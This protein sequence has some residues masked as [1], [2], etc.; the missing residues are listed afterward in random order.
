MKKLFTLL[1]IVSS[2][3]AS[4]Q[5]TWPKAYNSAKYLQFQ[6]DK[7]GEILGQFSHDNFASSFNHVGVPTTPTVPVYNESCAKYTNNGVATW[8]FNENYGFSTIIPFDNGKFFLGSFTSRILDPNGAP[9][10]VTFPTS[11]YTYHE[12]FSDQLLQFNGT[13]LNAIDINTGSVVNTSSIAALNTFIISSTY[14]KGSNL[15]LIGRY[16]STT[17]YANNVI[18]K[19][20]SAMTIAD[21]KTTSLDIRK[22]AITNPGTIYLCLNTEIGTFNWITAAYTLT[23]LTG[24]S[25]LLKYDATNTR[26]VY[27][28]AGTSTVKFIYDSGALTSYPISATGS[29]PTFGIEVD[30]YNNE[31]LINGSNSGP[32]GGTYNGSS[33]P[34]LATSSYANVVLHKIS[35]QRLRASFVVRN[36]NVCP[37]TPIRYYSNGTTGNPTNYSWSFPG[38]SPSTSTLSSPM[39]TYCNPGLYNASLTVSNCTSTH[40][41]NYTNFISV[42]YSNCSEPGCVSTVA[43][44]FGG[45]NSENAL[46]VRTDASGNIYTTGQFTGTVDFDPGAGV[47][48]LTSIASGYDMYITKFDAYGNFIWVK[49]LATQAGSASSANKADGLVIDNQGNLYVS[50]AYYQTVDFDP[51]AGVNT[52]TTGIYAEK[53]VLKLNT[54][55]EFVWVRKHG[56]SS[57]GTTASIAIDNANNIYIAGPLPNAT[58]TIGTFTITSAGNWDGYIARMDVLGNFVWAKRIGSSGV[59]YITDVKTNSAGSVVVGGLFSNTVDFDPNAG[60]ANL[61]SAGTYDAF[62]LTLDASGNYVW[63]KRTGSTGDD[64]ARELVINS[65]DDIILM[66]DYAGV[67]DFD[68]NAGVQNLTSAGGKDVY[69]QRL[70]SAGNYAWAGSMGSGTD[71]YG[72]AMSIDAA[73]NVYVSGDYSSGT[74]DV[75]PTAG[76]FNLGGTNGSYITK[77]N[78]SNAFVWGKKIDNAYITVMWNNPNNDLVVAGGFTGTT[79][80]DINAGVL[81]LSSNGSADA[82]VAK[83]CASSILRVATTEEVEGAI[84]TSTEALTS[85]VLIYPNP[86]LGQVFVSV[87][88]EWNTGKVTVYNSV[89]QIVLTGEVDSEHKTEFSLESLKDGLYFINVSNGE[90]SVTEKLIKNTNK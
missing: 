70:T 86:S 29:T 50:G 45:T 64:A 4:A 35:M 13:T 9:T 67:V 12:G 10:G 87:P 34:F 46:A 80:F 56:I 90:N 11:G 19:L 5:C 57:A 52:L 73:N 2:L 40:T 74:L 30:Y 59:D 88:A 27:F 79:D 1:F 47:S 55:G 68:P 82:F 16:F 8:M 41:A 48:T 61:T 76:V 44:S 37:G 33:F 21:V 65:A 17:N 84:A 51:G 89:G 3:I 28:N 69:V 53:F 77:I 15:Y 78:S 14:V 43:K 22:M 36:Q 72:R 83:Y 85:Q 20:N 23:E 54:C 60:V 81:N 42:S 25:A 63:A 31:L 18:I 71:N 66:G 58:I 75:D 6:F 7:Q 38:G 49:Q 32:A 26:I 24:Y 39:V 62:V